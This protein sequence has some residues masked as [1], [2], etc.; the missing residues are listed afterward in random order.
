VQSV[1]RSYAG[2][3]LGETLEVISQI[4]DIGLDTLGAGLDRSTLRDCSLPAETAATVF[5]ASPRRVLRNFAEHAGE[6]IVDPIVPPFYC[7]YTQSG[8]LPADGRHADVAARG[9]P[10]ERQHGDHNLERRSSAWG[11]VARSTAFLPQRRR[12]VN[13]LPLSDP[14]PPSVVR[15][16]TR[17][18]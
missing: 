15:Q 9:S 11:A 7:S 1:D 17:D 2:E 8:A 6:D 10:C 18:E 4:A 14:S 16:L 12:E 3:N 5:A 13:T